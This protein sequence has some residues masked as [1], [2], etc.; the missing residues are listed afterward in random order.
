MSAEEVRYPLGGRPPESVFLLLDPDTG[1]DLRDRTATWLLGALSFLSWRSH[2]YILAGPGPGA[3]EAARDVVGVVRRFLDDQ[4][5]AVVNVHPVGPL[6]IRET[7]ERARWEELLDLARPYQ[8]HAYEEQTEARIV[9]SPIVAL[10]RD[11]APS[12]L[13]EMVAFFHVRSATPSFYLRGDEWEKRF[14]GT[15]LGRVRL[16]LDGGGEPD[17]AR[18]LWAS[19][20]LEDAIERAE[21]EG[22][23][24]LA[25]CR[26]HL[27]ADERS[28]R[29]FA[30]FEQW[31]AGTPAARLEAA[32]VDAL[33]VPEERCARC[34]AGALL[35][36]RE[37]LVANARRAEGRR[38]FF[39][40]ASA[41][42][43]RG[44]H[45]LAADLA[46]HARELSDSDVDR[47]AALI[48]EGLCLLELRQLERA[49]T[50]LEAATRCPVDQGY[51]AYQRGQVQFAWRDWIEALDRYEEALE[52]G[53]DQVPTEDI[54]YQ[55]ALSHI[56]LEEYEEARPYLERSVRP[57]PPTAPIAFYRGICDLGQGRVEQAMTHF[58]E[59]LRI[60]P[61]SEDL[62]RVLFYLGTCLKEQERFDEAI[63]VLVRAVEAD[64]EDLANHNLLGFCYYKTKRHEEAVR[65]FVRAV[66][67][68]PR[69]GIDW[70]NLGSNL[71]DL[72]RIEE[73][74]RM[75]RKALSLDPTLGWVRQNLA[76]LLETPGD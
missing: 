38:A 49:E 48:H 29:L 70:A 68:D 22:A 23:E 33:P 66:Q 37:D 4:E 6:P 13:E 42:S 73:A 18:R 14:E 43:A 71:R 9:I 27:V 36:V 26:R 60:G 74:V 19:H 11:I 61:A 31:S 20:I 7:E 45:T 17:V 12:D 76:R 56:N 54:C 32:A 21:I 50:L 5:L 57:G 8:R 67:I 3:V 52:F 65:C 62:G 15:D 58:E 63:E 10:D 39:A 59:S 2:V 55:A 72:G 1:P 51:V 46:R 44:E 34:I 41:C 16:Y 28:G 40:A 35:E 24:L 25:P 30:C 53:S 47:G 69:S 64:P 75:Y